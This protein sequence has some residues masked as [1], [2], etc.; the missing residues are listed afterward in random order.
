MKHVL[1][2]L[3]FSNLFFSL[4][5]QQNFT[6]SGIIKDK[7]GEI[8]PGVGVYVSGYKIATSTDNSGKYSLSLPAGNYDILVQAIGFI[9]NNKNVI[10]KDQ[11][12]KLDFILEES[13]IQLAEVTIRPDPNRTLHQCFQKF[14]YWQHAKL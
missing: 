9:A 2:I 13:T 4:A 8:I 7:K 12:Q 3:F 5:A 14:L 10:I 11:T 6:L 1:L